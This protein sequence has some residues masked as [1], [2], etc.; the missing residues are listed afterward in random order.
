MGHARKFFRRT[1][2]PRVQN[3]QEDSSIETRYFLLRRAAIYL[4]TTENALRHRVERRQIPFIKRG[5]TVWFDRVALDRWERW[6]PIF[7][8][9]VKVESRSD[10][11]N[12]ECHE[13]DGATRLS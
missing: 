4:G 12:L 1:H 5:G 7:G 6:T 9:V 3:L 2:R 10:R 13:R 8:Q 11:R